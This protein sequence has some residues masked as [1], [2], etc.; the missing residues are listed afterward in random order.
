MMN[1][2]FTTA[3]VLLFLN[4]VPKNTTPSGKIFRPNTLFQCVYASAVIATLREPIELIIRVS[5]SILILLVDVTER[6]TPMHAL[7]T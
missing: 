2:A 4:G 6:F 1:L 5:L 7:R 3:P